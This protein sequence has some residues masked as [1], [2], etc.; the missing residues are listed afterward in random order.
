MNRKAIGIDLGT[1]YSCVAIVGNSGKPEVLLNADGER[2]T[3]SAVWFD[4]DRRIVVGEEAKQEAPLSP[5]EV[6][7]F[8][9]REMGRDS[10]VFSC[11]QGDFRP[12]EVSAYILKKLV[13]DASAR[14]GQEIRDVVITCPAYF[15]HKEREATKAAGQ[16]AGLNVLEILNEPTAAAMAYGLSGAQGKSNRH[17]LVYDL[18][19]GTF[20]VTIIHVS[21]SGLNVVCTDGNHLLGGK[22]WDDVMLDMLVGRL[23]QSADT[24]VDLKSDAAA[25]Q[26]LRLL[27]E[28]TKKLLTSKIEV[29]TSYKYR[30][31]KLY[32]SISREEF[33]RE[34]ESL[35]NRTLEDTRHAVEVARSK[36][37][38][39]VDE[40]ILVGGSTYMPQVPAMLRREFGL[41]PV[42]YDPDEAVAKGAA[43]SAM[44]HLLREEAGDF[45]LE[46]NTEGDFSLETKEKLQ[47]LADEHDMTLEAIST[48]VTPTYNV[49]S[50]SFGEIL[51]RQSDYVDRIYNILYKNTTLPAEATLTSYTLQ[52]NQ[53]GVKTRVVD[54]MVEMPTSDAE[55]YA[56]STEGIDP[57]LGNVIWEGVLPIKPGLPKGSPIETI[58]RLSED[59]LLHILSRD[60]A[61]GQTIEGEVK[62]DS[63]LSVSEMRQMQR[64]LNNM[65]IE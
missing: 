3:P 30:G 57:A 38:K 55:I 39:K 7:T 59:G 34:T 35:L 40:L 56:I 24:A 42:T 62:T 51:V 17:I 1:T 43:I 58:F 65:T 27:A 50:R 60:P 61:S 41:E 5:G 29:Q 44:A 19:G 36:G 16:L 52:D 6:A 46:T 14:L 23:Q 53:T 28:K 20:D 4:E 10:Y 21:P 48:I 63:S 8:I 33:E 9:K 11:S 25:M 15:S 12:E 2:T 54:N 22:D 32:A 31:E 47:Q 18:G 13:Q 26:D 37:V 64:K 45:S 49:S